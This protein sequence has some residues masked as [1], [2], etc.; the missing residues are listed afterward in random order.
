MNRQELLEPDWKLIFHAWRIVAEVNE[1]RKEV[2]RWT[3]REIRDY[4]MVL[5]LF[6]AELRRRGV[7]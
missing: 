1:L 4:D 7:S 3:R 6:D 5:E 2:D